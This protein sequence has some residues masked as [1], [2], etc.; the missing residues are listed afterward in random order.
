MK[1]IKKVFSNGSQVLHLW[2]NQSQSD[3]RSSNV[4]FEGNTA[5][6]YGYHFPLGQIHDFN[7]HKI[8]VLTSHSYSNTTAKHKNWSWSA[9][10]HLIQLSSSKVDCLDAALLETQ[11]AL[12]DDLSSNFTRRSF[13][14]GSKTNHYN[15]YYKKQVETFNKTCDVLKQSKMKLDVSQDFIESMNDHVK[16]CL[17]HQKVLDAEFDV[18][19]AKRQLKLAEKLKVTI[20]LRKNG[21]PLT[22]DLRMLRPQIIR[23][24]GD[25]VETSSGA[26][27]PLNEAKQLL[28]KLINKTA[29]ENESIGSFKFNNLTNGIVV[30]GCH[31]ISLE[32]AKQVLI[33][34][35]LV[36]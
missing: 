12:I 28:S 29:K 2:A 34:L 10:S 4:F 22:S 16:A 25:L 31:Q 14:S 19:Q 33:P 21:G 6:S 20:D 18:R 15:E 13:Y 17:E 3:A 32:Q 1:R 5:Y 9:T 35:T 30:I 8:A 11:T 7:G 24:Q 27:V 23:V 36:A 26:S